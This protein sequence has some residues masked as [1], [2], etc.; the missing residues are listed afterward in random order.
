[1]KKRLI[2]ALCLAG[3]TAGGRYVVADQALYQCEGC[4]PA[5]VV[6]P[7]YLGPGTAEGDA[8]TLLSDDLH[9][10]VGIVRVV[11]GVIRVDRFPHR[12]VV[13]GY[14]ESLQHAG[15]SLVIAIPNDE[16]VIITKEGV[17]QGTFVF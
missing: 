10:V 4:L 17:R 6:A 13:H 15:D 5:V 7:E 2:W 14:P 16:P 9:M 11:A 1:M 12:H 3:C 8:W